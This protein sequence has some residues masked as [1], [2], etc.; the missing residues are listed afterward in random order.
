VLQVLQGTASEIALALKL[1][2]CVVALEA[3]QDHIGVLHATS[4]AE[5]VIMAI[6][7]VGGAA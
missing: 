1:Q 6:T 7:A 2:R 3:R 4:P 5:A